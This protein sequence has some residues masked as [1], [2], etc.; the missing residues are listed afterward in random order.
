[1]RR[2]S[3]AASVNA[4]R[5]AA[6]SP[7]RS[8]ASPRASSTGPASSLGVGE[9]ERVERAGEALGRVLVGEPVERA[10][11]R[12]D[13]HLGGAAGVGGLEQVGGDLLEVAVLAERGERVGRA[14]V[15]PLAAQRR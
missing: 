6:G 8:S 1:M 2:A 12:A 3:C 7:A 10:A 15:Q 13:E 9:R 14:P 4:S 11:A 5:A